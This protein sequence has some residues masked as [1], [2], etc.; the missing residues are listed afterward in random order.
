MTPYLYASCVER[1]GLGILLRGHAGAGKSSFS[2]SLI[3]RGLNLVGDDQVFLRNV[4]GKLFASPA[5]S[6]KGLLEVRGVGILQLKYTPECEIA[7]LIDLVPGYR[8]ERLPEMESVEIQ[9]VPLRSF[10]INPMDPRAIEKVFV[11]LHPDF[12]GFYSDQVESLRA[13]SKAAKGA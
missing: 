3:N 8:S 6:L 13:L 7:Y 11:L 12:E 4:E 10:H 5:E 9:G 1:D 2:L